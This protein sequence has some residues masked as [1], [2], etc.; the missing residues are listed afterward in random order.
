MASHEYQAHVVWDGDTGEG[1]AAYTAY[2]RRYRVLV[3]GKPEIAG[4]ADP[5]FRGEADRHNPEDLFLAAVSACHMLAY[6]ALCARGGVRVL[7]YEDRAAGTLVLHPAGG[8]RFE[9]IVLHPTVHVGGEEQAEEAAR[10]HEVA[11]ERCFIASSCSV[12]IRVEPLIL[13]RAVEAADAGR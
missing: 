11:H 4:S 1:T 8:G 5:V 2:E 12:P 3:A 6:L 9:Q 7:A 13:T 10:L